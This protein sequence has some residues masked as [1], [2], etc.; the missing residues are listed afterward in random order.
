[1]TKQ[2]HVEVNST[3][4]TPLG[5]IDLNS[6]NMSQDSRNTKYYVKTY[7]KQKI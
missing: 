2:T 4:T 5:H 3:L 6:D 7:V 1:M